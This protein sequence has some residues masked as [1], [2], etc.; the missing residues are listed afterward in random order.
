MS[1][2]LTFTSCSSVSIVNFE[3]VIAGWTITHCL[4]NMAAAV[5]QRCSEKILLS[6]NSHGNTSRVFY[7]SKIASTLRGK[8]L[9][10]IELGGYLI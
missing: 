4:T 2:L 6:L 7:F 3:H 9:K 8:Y 5:A 1:L 10:D